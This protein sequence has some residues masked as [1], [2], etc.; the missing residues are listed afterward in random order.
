MIATYVY[1]CGYT[2]LTYHC[3]VNGVA[4]VENESYPPGGRLL[5]CYNTKGQ[6]IAGPMVSEL[7]AWSCPQ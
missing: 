1:K 2:G 5:V 6:A 4:R 7:L 3:Q